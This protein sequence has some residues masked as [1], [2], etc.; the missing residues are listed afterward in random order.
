MH[1][2]GVS[3]DTLDTFG[4]VS[5]ETAY[6]MAKGIAMANHAEVFCLWTALGLALTSGFLS[7]MRIKESIPIMKK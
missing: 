1:Y 7:G 2:L 3:K 5:E 4:A 6:E